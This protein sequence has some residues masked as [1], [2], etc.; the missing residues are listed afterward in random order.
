MAVRGI[1]VRAGESE[2]A[3]EGDRGGTV[4]RQDDVTVRVALGRAHVVNGETQLVQRHLRPV[5]Q[6]RVGIVGLGRPL[7]AVHRRPLGS[8][9]LGDLRDH[10]AYVGRSVDRHLAVAHQREHPVEVIRVRVGHEDRAQWLVQR[11]EPGPKRRDVGDQQVGVHHHDAPLALDEIGI[12]EQP[13][14]GCPVGVYDWSGHVVPPWP[15]RGR[16]PRSRV[17]TSG[18][19]TVAGQVSKTSCDNCWLWMPISGICGTSW[20]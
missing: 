14:F 12:D 17:P 10:P 6:Q 5:G 7:L 3:G 20:P 2:V 13:G 1:R 11:R 15:H 8:F 18:S 16:T 19:L 4:G 9:R